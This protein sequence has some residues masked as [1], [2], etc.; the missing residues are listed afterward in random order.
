[1]DRRKAVTAAAAASLTLLAGAAG[2]TL[3][4]GI[5][6]ASG[7]GKVG[8]LSPVNATANPPTTIYVDVPAT[9]AQAAGTPLVQPSN[10]KPVT[11]SAASGHQSDDS[12]EH[13]SD[14]HHVYEGA[15]D[16][17]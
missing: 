3:N 12:S 13:E 5:V 8:Q 10:A 11:T 2:I 15:E 7:D 14:D 16:D 4:S 6:G 1:M 17:D 9:T